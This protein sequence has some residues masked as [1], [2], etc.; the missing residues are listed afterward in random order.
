MAYEHDNEDVLKAEPLA[1]QA[2]RQLAEQTAERAADMAAERT[3]RKIVEMVFGHM[4]VDVNDRASVKE[5]RDNL[6]FL[7]RFNQGTTELKRAAVR[8]AVGI[9]LAGICTL[10]W[11]GF[12]D[13]FFQV[14]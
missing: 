6:A 13:Y 2:I 5:L 10:L 9:A 3:A 4:G 7:A 1:Q 11:L 8:S 14:H 12:K